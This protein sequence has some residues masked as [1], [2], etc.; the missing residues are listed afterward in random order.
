LE[1][2]IIVAAVSQFVEWKK[3]LTI[4]EFGILLFDSFFIAKM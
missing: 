2:S 4:F 1:H 3:N